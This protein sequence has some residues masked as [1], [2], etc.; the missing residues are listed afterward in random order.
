[1]RIEMRIDPSGFIRFHRRFH[2][3]C[4]RLSSAPSMASSKP[5]PALQ[6]AIR[7]HQAGRW[8]KAESIY[9]QVLAR[10][11]SQPDALHRL[12]ILAARRG[13]MDEAEKLMRRAIDARPDFPDALANLANVLIARENF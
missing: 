2:S 13:Q 12:G 9:R 6:S 10:Q 8:D 11:P 5:D 4:H 1:M 7:H 3:L